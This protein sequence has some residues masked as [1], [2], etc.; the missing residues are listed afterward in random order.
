MNFKKPPGEPCVRLSF[1]IRVVQP[2]AFDT[3]INNNDNTTND[4]NN[5]IEI[6]M[7]IMMMIIMMIIMLIYNG[8]RY[9]IL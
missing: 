7:I 9:N 3:D 4:N 8:I 6:M 2:Q 1:S 5:I